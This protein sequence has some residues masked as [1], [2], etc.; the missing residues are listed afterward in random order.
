MNVD[1]TR[2][3]DT[4]VLEGYFRRYSCYELLAT[5]VYEANAPHPHVIILRQF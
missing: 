2:F 3:R 4:L 5:Q 1:N